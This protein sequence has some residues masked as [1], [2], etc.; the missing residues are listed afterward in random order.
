MKRA[1]RD[2]ASEGAKSLSLISSPSA[3]SPSLAKQ[4]SFSPPRGPSDSGQHLRAISESRLLEEREFP[5]QLNQVLGLL[6]EGRGVDFAERK[7]ASIQRTI[8]QRMALN[9]YNKLADYLRYLHDHSDEVATLEHDLLINRTSFF[10]DPEAF[11]ALKS[12]VYPAILKDRSPPD[13]IRIWVPGCSSGEEAYSHAITLMEYLLESQGDFAIQIFG[14]DLSEPAIRQARR[15]IYDGSIHTEISPARLRRFFTAV[16]D[17]YRISKAVRDLCVFATQNV[18]ADPPFSRMDLVSCRN[19]LVNMRPSLQRKV[20]ARLH[21]ALKPEGFLMVGD[22]EATLGSAGLFEKADQKHKIY[23]KKSARRPASFRFKTRNSYAGP[24][25][26]EDT[27]VASKEPPSL[28]ITA[29]LHK[30]AERL[31][32]ARYAPAAVVVNEKLEILQT[33]GGT[34]SYLNLPSGRTNGN[35]LKMARPCLLSALKAAIRMA[36]QRNISVRK[37]NIRFDQGSYSSLVNIEVAPFRSSQHKNDRKFLIVFEHAPV[38]LAPAKKRTGSERDFLKGQVGQLRQELAGIKEFLQATIEEQ[39]SSY[40]RLHFANEEIQSTNEELQ[41]RNSEL[42]SANEELRTTNEELQAYRAE[43]E[44]TNQELSAVND[45]V[46]YSDFQLT[47]AKNDIVNIPM[48]TLGPDFCVRRYTPPAESALGLTSNDIGR[49]ITHLR[50]MVSM[51]NLEALLHDVMRNAKPVQQEIQDSKGTWYRLRVMPYRTT[52]GTVDGA[53]LT[54]MDI[55]DLKRSLGEQTEGRAKL[56]EMLH[57]M[58]S[59]LLVADARSGKLQMGNNRLSEILGHDMLAEN[60]VLDY[61]AHALDPDGAPLDPKKWAI[62]RSMDGEVVTGEEIEWLRADGR[63]LFLTVNS[64]PIRDKAGNVVSVVATF[65]DMTYRHSAENMLRVSEQMA[66]TGRLAAALAHEINNPLEAL[67]NLN[68]LLSRGENLD[69][70]SRKYVDM[71]RVELNRITHISKSLLGLYRAE[72]KTESFLIRDVIEEVLEVF[73]AKIAAAKTQILTRFEV[74][75]MMHGSS[76]EIRQLFLN[77]V[78][79][80]LE[81]MGQNG[82]LILRTSASRDWRDLGVRGLRISVTDNGGGIPRD[83]VPRVFEP[84]FTTKGAKGTGLGLWVSSGIVHRYG[85]KIRVRSRVGPIT[86]GTTF[87]I[88][89]PN[90]TVKRS[91][92]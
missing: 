76:T 27:A 50:T 13:A 25:R 24:H 21:Y 82:V 81:A 20:I 35:L 80:A 73:R 5:A 92:N 72:S 77:L 19:V 7:L 2:R 33:R 14:T 38:P 44:L 89:F 91:V 79:N 70:E 66:A 8:L 62:A 46:Q 31:L 45:R 51:E 68:Y 17:G 55:S 88:F 87:S 30:E 69:A 16:K 11:E 39:A 29:G 9:G 53:V 85:G 58:Q 18:C 63:H 83:L 65:V 57:L 22:T 90:A 71:A 74:E 60:N 41:C 1:A 4:G 3:S 26:N 40:G 67:T 48:V 36:R 34:S 28:D 52:D 61:A 86:S 47:Q 10:H 15:G 64:A 37:E 49:P 78:G 42:E 23:R 54:L 84:F 6:R 32:L 56:E 59:G 43:L 75:G 12:V